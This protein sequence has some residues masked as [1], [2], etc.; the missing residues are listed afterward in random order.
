MHLGPLETFREVDGFTSVRV[1]QIVGRTDCER[2]HVEDPRD[3][4]SLRTAR[5]VNTK[6]RS[7]VQTGS[8]GARRLSSVLSCDGRIQH[9]RSMAVPEDIPRKPACEEEVNI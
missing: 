6:I 4:R 1:V 7:D 3:S 5:T 2:L 8:E 9:G